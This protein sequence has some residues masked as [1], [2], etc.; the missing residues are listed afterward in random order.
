[1]TSSASWAAAARVVR[2]TGFGASGALVDAVAQAGP[3]AWL[4]ASLTA[5][6]DA[7]PGATATPAPSIPIVPSLGK[8]ATIDE[9]RQRRQHEQDQLA[10][11]VRWWVTR[12]VTAENPVVEKLTFGWHNHFA[13]SATKVKSATMLL[14]QNQQ[15]RALGRGR[16]GDLAGAMVVDPAMLYWLDAQQNSVKAPNEN[17]SREFMELFTLGHG[18][19]YTEQDV[20]EGARALTGWTL[21]KGDGT[22]TFVPNRHDTKPKTV[23]GIT[24]NLDAAGFVQAVLA[25][26]ASAPFVATRWWNLIASPDA[27]PAEALSRMTAAY[28]PSRDLAALFGAVV[29]DP[30]YAAA[31]GTLVASPVE[32][33]VGAMR[34]LAVKP[35]DATVKKAAAAMRALGQLPLYPPNVSGWP[36]GQAWLSTAS[37]ATRVQTATMLA[38]AGDLH[39]VQ[40]APPATRVDAVAHLLGIPTFTGRTAAEL[41]AHTNDPQRLVA[42]ALVSPE[43][44]VI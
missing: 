38:K 43:N 20:R 3:A 24:A 22:A 33:V 36:S 27:P 23:L 14:H 18:G 11:L 31:A 34:S 26:P 37:A 15:L 21:S 12:M 1:M 25:Q 17:L 30:A 42:A 8:D 39:T 44:L 16:F 9:R 5:P 29:A 4:S 35:D 41:K 2:S 28:G 19:G 6:V 32:W 40:D 10:A 7:D 13:T